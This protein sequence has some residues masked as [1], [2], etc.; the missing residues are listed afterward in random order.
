[1]GQGPWF[2]APIITYQGDTYLQQ[3]FPLQGT[4]LE[5]CLPIDYTGWTLKMQ[6]REALDPTSTLLLTLDNG[7]AGGLTLVSGGVVQGVSF[8]TPAFVNGIQ[9]ALTAAQ[10]TALPSGEWYYD[11]YGIDALA[12]QHVQMQGQFIVNA[13]VTR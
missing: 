5:D 4:S 13:T 1:V 6:I 8:T 7:G 11:M 3:F 12:T 10:T 9:I 2:Q